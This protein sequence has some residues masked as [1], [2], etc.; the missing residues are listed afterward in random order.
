M[1]PTQFFAR[2]S[3]TIFLV[4]VAILAGQ[5]MAEVSGETIVATSKVLFAILGLSIVFTGICAVW[6]AD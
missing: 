4:T 3:A 2:L 1:G 5:V 6:E